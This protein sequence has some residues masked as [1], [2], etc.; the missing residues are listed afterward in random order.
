MATQY[1]A[2]LTTGQVLTAATMDSIGAEWE[3]W[4][5]TISASAGAI[6]TGAVTLARYMRIQK[7]VIAEFAYTITTA[8][9]AANA[10]LRF[11][12]PIT[13]HSSIFDGICL[14][15]GREYGAVGFALT[16][17][18]LGTNIQISDYLGAGWIQNGRAASVTIVYEAA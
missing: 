15:L 11:T 13:P 9:T 10:S 14:G 6:T 18:K 4:T 1:N 5:P 3:T 12:P 2:G 7:L 17:L 8:G 16:T